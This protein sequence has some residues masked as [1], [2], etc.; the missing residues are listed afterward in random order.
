MSRAF[1]SLIFISPQCTMKGV[2]V[3]LDAVDMQFR[4]PLHWAA[5]LGLSEV[6]TLLLN[7]GANPT[8]PDAVGATALHYAVSIINILLV[9]LVLCTSG[10]IGKIGIIYS[11]CV[12]IR[13]GD[14]L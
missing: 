6:M 12:E 2:K 11:V 14:N 8:I 3:D 4:S 7:Y 13:E 1:V 5:V 10:N 9:G